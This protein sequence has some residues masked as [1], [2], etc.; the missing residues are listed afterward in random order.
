MTAAT[1]TSRSARRATRARRSTAGRLARPGSV[2]R[3]GVARRHLAVRREPPGTDRA[4]RPALRDGHSQRRGHGLEPPGRPALRAAARTRRPLPVVVAVLLA[5][6]ERGAA[7]GRVLQGHR[8]LRRRLAVLLLRPDA[9]QEAAQPRVR[10]RRREGRQGRASSRNRSSAFPGT[11][12][13]NDLLFYDGDQFPERYRRGAF[14]AFHGSDDPHAVL[15]GRLLRGVRAV[16]RTARRPGLGR[17]SPTGSPA[18]TRS[19]TRAMPRRGRWDW[20]RGRTGRSTSATASR[21]RSGA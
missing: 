20:R 18:S 11:G 10:R 17:C 2:R 16:R 9:G 3:A 7:V 6:A 14:I 21:A 4:G 8:R 19:S 1:C 15:A 13:P 12:R 5:M